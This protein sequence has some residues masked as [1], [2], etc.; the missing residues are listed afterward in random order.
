M[1]RP[2]QAGLAC[3]KGA[4]FQA[5][6]QTESA[7]PNR[8]HRTK[9]P[10]LLPSRATG[11]SGQSLVRGPRLARDCATRGR[12]PTT[13]SGRGSALALPNTAVA[14]MQGN[15][16]APPHP[17]LPGAALTA[18][19]DGTTLGQVRSVQ[20]A[21][22]WSH[23][24]GARRSRAFSPQLHSQAHPVKGLATIEHSS[25]KTAL[26]QNLSWDQQQQ[27]E[28]QQQEERGQS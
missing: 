10:L 1:A 11:A 21:R 18:Q 2:A 28:K 12:D 14:A 8:S 5:V 19:N 22:L 9:P 23:Y 16:R 6:P 15:R 25:K 13:S 26:S 4:D 17:G 27:G 24:A 7:P 20:G 3:S